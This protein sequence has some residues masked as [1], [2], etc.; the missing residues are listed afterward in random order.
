MFWL[1]W[2]LFS[3]WLCTQC[4]LIQLI[5]LLPKLQSQTQVLYIP[6]PNT[7]CDVSVQDH[8]TLGLY[9]QV[10]IYSLSVDI[11]FCWLLPWCAG[12]Y[13]ITE[14]L[15]QILSMVLF[16]RMISVVWKATKQNH[17]VYTTS[18]NDVIWRP[19][20]KRSAVLILEF[21]CWHLLLSWCRQSNNRA[22]RDRSH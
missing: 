12:I 21:K 1:L 3:E 16:L 5:D 4:R 10:L 14:P 20:N 11:K 9:F 15:L 7:E 19:Y 13:P 6:L 22:G 2:W 8:T 17:K 18:R